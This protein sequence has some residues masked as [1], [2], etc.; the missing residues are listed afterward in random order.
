MSNN[1]DDYFITFM[2]KANENLFL[3]SSWPRN[4]GTEIMAAVYEFP[5]ASTITTERLA[6]AGKLITNFLMLS[7]CGP[8]IICLNPIFLIIILR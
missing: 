1:A 6:K 2:L 4:P 3:C 7:F 5:I 8:Q